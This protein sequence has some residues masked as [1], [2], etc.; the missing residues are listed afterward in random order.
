MTRHRPI[1]VLAAVLALLALTVPTASAYDP[2]GFDLELTPVVSGLSQPVLVTHAGDGSDRLFI[3][4]QGGTV[5]IFKNGSLVSLP[6]IDL[7]ASVSD[8]YEQ[9]LLGLAFHPD[10][11]TNGKF[12]VNFTTN[13]GDTAINEYRVGTNR[14]RVLAGSGRRVITIQQPFDNHNGGHIAFGRDGYLYVGMGDGG[15][16]GDPQDR[17]QSLG[18]ML[19]KMLRID[20]DSPTTT[21]GY[22]VPASNPYVGKSGLDEIWSSGLRN[23]WRWSID[24]ANGALWIGDVGQD[25]YEEIS[26]AYSSS[27]YPVGGRALDFGWDTLEGRVCFEPA[28]GCSSAGTHLPIVTYPQSGGRCAVTGGYVYRGTAEPLMR[29]G[30]FFADY[31]SG[32]IWTIDAKAAS[33]ATRK[34]LLDTTLK[35][36]S[37]GEDEDGELYVVDLN[38]SV[39]HMTASAN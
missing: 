24:R 14:D 5:R 1:R 9:G 11:E 37:F 33:P 15:S 36:S 13:G 12:Y 30:Y 22:R 26:R 32:E 27:T 2:N 29:G 18:S 19:G 16:G 8:G 38:G 17:A 25:R 28:S 20:A 34:L 4:E 39:Y 10:H 31:C 35:I 7:T 23:P 6:L 3:V 21:K